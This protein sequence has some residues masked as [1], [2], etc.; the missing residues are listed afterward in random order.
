MA[1]MEGINW[2]IVVVLVAGVLVIGYGWFAD[3]E[4]ERR[5]RRALASPPEREIPGYDGSDAP[6]YLTADQVLPLPDSISP[7]LTDAE[8]A[9][10]ELRKDSATVPVGTPDGHFLN[11]PGVGLAVWSDPVVLVST[12]PIETQREALTALAAGRRRGRPM[13]WVA[14]SFSPD[15]LGTLV[16]NTASRKVRVLPIELSD[17][18]HVS[19][20]CS[21]TG[22]TPVSGAD[23]QMEYLPD[24]VWGTCGGW[25]ADADD[26]W[27]IEA[28]ETDNH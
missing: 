6:T 10:V 19:R 16:M 15:V 17:P 11:H 23:L 20:V 2:G 22:A 12:D 9:L 28:S 7:Q 13:V 21:L 4:R 24:S 14:P 8:L 26:S 25:V 27:I 5:E 1:D 18:A 3:A